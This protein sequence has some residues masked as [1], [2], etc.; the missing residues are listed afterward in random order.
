MTP[1]LTEQ[2][3]QWAC[4]WRWAPDE[5][6]I[7]GGPVSSWCCPRDSITTP[8][9]TVA[10]VAKALV[11]WRDWL[12]D[13]AARF[14]RYPMELFSDGDQLEAWE[15]GAV[16]LVHHVVDRTGAGDAWYRHCAQVLTWFLAR[17]GMPE[18]QAKPLVD[19]AIGG[20]FSSW[21]A[22]EETAVNDIAE[23]LARMAGDAQDGRHHD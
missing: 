16:H 19:E 13:L 3:G 5:G 12:E 10:R 14:D 17:W 7:G 6:D 15:R 8:E 2:F 18:E 21:I 11:E 9:E 4:G 23:R 20:R 1:A 22:P